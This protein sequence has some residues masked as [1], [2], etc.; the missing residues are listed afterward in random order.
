[1]FK[2]IDF[3]NFEKSLGPAYA[4]AN[5]YEY[6]AELTTAYLGRNRLFFPLNRDE[7]RAGDEVGYELMKDTWSIVDYKIFNGF[8][9][10]IDLY[11]CDSAKKKLGHIRNLKANLAFS[12]GGWANMRLL[13]VVSGGNKV[14]GFDSRTNGGANWNLSPNGA[15][16]QTSIDQLD[17]SMKA[18][19]ITPAKTP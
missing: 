12:F 8:N 11:W 3:G 6:F 16:F 18:S 14:Y 13:V 10:D 2:P 4:K 1:V 17:G 5:A 15:V 9:R 19:E 7:L